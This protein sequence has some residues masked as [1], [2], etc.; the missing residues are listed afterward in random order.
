MSKKIIFYVA[1]IGLFLFLVWVTLQKGE[2]LSSGIFGVLSHS[3]DTESTGTFSRSL[4][5]FLSNFHHPLG[6]L[7]LQVLVILAVSRLVGILFNM[8]N[9]PAVIGEIFAGIMLGPSLLGLFLPQ[10][11]EFIFPQSSLGNLQ[12]LSQIGLILFM[13]IIGM[14]LDVNILKNKAHE[15]VLLSHASII[16]PYFLGVLVSYFIYL[17][18]A[19]QGVRFTSFALFM[20]IAMSI[21][22]FPVLARIIQERGLT[23]TPLGII[24]LTCA[25]ADDVTAWCI[26]ALVIAIVKAGN[27]AGA[28][29]TVL[30]ATV[31]VIFMLKV[32]QPFLV[33]ISRIYIRTYISKKNVNKTVIAFVFAVLFAS[34]YLSEI[35]GIHALFGA[36]LAGVIMPDELN[37]KSLIAEKIEDVSIVLLLPLFFVF[38]GLRTQIGLINEPYHWLICLLLIGV[39]ILGKLGGSTIAARFVGL[40]WKN[41]LSIGTLMNTRGLMEL[42]V[43][44]IGYDLGVLSPEIFAMMVIMAVLT[45][46]LAGPLLELINRVFKEKPEPGALT[47]RNRILISYARPETGVSLLKLA[48][49]L[50]GVNRTA[51]AI[52][53]LH[54]AHSED[55]SFQDFS[56]LEKNHSDILD[57]TAEELNIKVEPIYKSAANITR[58]IIKELSVQNSDLLLLG[59]AKPVFTNDILG[60][61]IRH[62]IQRAKANIGVLIDRGL[63]KVE[64]VLF[65]IHENSDMYLLKYITDMLASPGLKLTVYD[66]DKLLSDAAFAEKLPDEFNKRLCVSDDLIL[67]KTYLDKHDLLVISNTYWKK[68]YRMLKRT[69]SLSSILIVTPR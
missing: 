68:T 16:F 63:L 35:I 11:S 47:V 26:L 10:V 23:K 12:F 55:L 64:N 33:K 8:I 9:Q 21:T 39:A 5:E 1:F 61:K 13:F 52:K 19:P 37:F 46:F 2:A 66:P 42:V 20:G 34:A 67:E 15:A 56:M 65:V 3:Q 48:A 22:A 41:A 27:A 40:S 50:I 24:A 25:A 43:L 14:E 6:I 30:S 36:F 58:E 69:E 4:K 31:Y 57:K 45:T 51:N 28:A 60:G 7:L 54:I 29:F 59:T 44:N 17:D 49:S 32:V 38:T 62:V 18:F 53:T